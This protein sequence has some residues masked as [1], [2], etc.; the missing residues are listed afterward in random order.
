MASPLYQLL[1]VSHDRLGRLSG[2]RSL[3]YK[4]CYDLI[5][6]RLSN[7]SRKSDANQTLYLLGGNG[8]TA[9][10]WDLAVPHFR[11]AQPV[12]L[13]L[14]GF[15][16][17]RSPQ[18]K[19]LGQLAE[20]LLAATEPGGRIFAVG[21]NG[22]VV[23]HALSRRPGHFEQS[24]LLAPVGAFLWQRR[25]VQLMSIKP[26]RKLIH[27]LLSR[28]PQIFGRFT[29][30]RWPAEYYE[31]IARGYRNCRAFEDYFDFVRPGNALDLL[32]WV[33]DRVD[34]V[35]GGADR[36]LSTRQMAAWDAI[37]P[38]AELT[39]QVHP[40][41][42]HYPYFDDP[43]EFAQFVE[44]F[45]GGFPAHTKAG[46]LQLAELAGLPV[47]QQTAVRDAEELDEAVQDLREECL[48]AV[49]SSGAREDHIDQSLAGRHRTFLRV[50]AAD[51]AHRAREL[52]EDDGLEGVVIQQFVEPKVSGV[53]FCRWLSLEVEY[54]WG[55]LEQ[56][57]RGDAAPRRAI[58]SKLPGEWSRAPQPSEE[59]PPFDFAGLQAF[60]RGCLRAFHD[61]PADIEWGWD[62]Q[63]F[64][65]LQIRPVT[66]YGWRRCLTSANL[67]E[68]LPPTVSRL[69]EHAQRRASLAISRIYALWD[70][71]V[72]DDHEPFTAVY[73]DASY[74][75]LD[76][77][78]SRM[79][80]WGLPSSLLAEEIGGSVPVFSFSLGR[81]LKSLPRLL[82]MHFVV[83][84][85]LAHIEPGLR[86]FEAELT[87][88]LAEPAEAV[89]EASLV[90][91][92]VRYYVFIVRQNMIINA[93]L[94]SSG[95][96]L[97]GRG[98]TVYRQL[99]RD[100]HPHRV[101]FESDP[102]SPRTPGADPNL[103]SLP[104]WGLWIRLLHA[105]GA[106]GLRGHYTQV[107]EW[108]R[109]SN[110]KLFYR[111][112]HALRGSRWLEPHPGQRS[113]RGTF[114]QDGGA[115]AGQ[116]RSFVIY[117]GEVTGVVG[118]EI[119]VVDALDPGQFENYRCHRAVIART[120]GRLSHGATLLRELAKPS[121]VIPDF[122]RD[123]QGRRIVLSGD[124]YQ[125]PKSE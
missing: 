100:G 74:I 73:Q 120:G 47:P 91:W 7:S 14:P 61:H 27:A 112:H 10:W 56:L 52:L 33:T 62:G 49:R 41:W 119:L 19:S 44:G 77:F 31:K 55:H 109:D 17:N 1:R 99:D 86:D 104:P 4:G 59:H 50:P 98:R 63:S 30:K 67:D 84:G 79:Y 68:L 16:N 15:G 83:R 102:A 32:E 51:V 90:D 65:L 88:L 46:R 70:A 45:R 121:A 23:L 76:L 24:I 115:A 110:M 3:T 60:L 43:A 107:R 85:R 93:A 114:W 75:N 124:R 81:F 9:Q 123:L 113:Q 21:I 57:V 29:N 53:A 8:S 20:A 66:S 82:R 13:E 101:P 122:P 111:L 64:Y 11:Q 37:L 87:R 89:R 125:V 36:I 38:R 26:L 25:F 105:L 116:Q 12:P 106:P 42:G 5:G 92:F 72:L 40:E 71:R 6:E 34:I 35:W 2:T 58:F 39:M 95:G 97:W 22:L 54:V 69:M 78:L 103:E 28:R 80:D 48:Y 117:P 96:S 94:A 18:H 118:E 108:F